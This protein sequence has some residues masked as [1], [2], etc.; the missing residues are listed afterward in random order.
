MGAYQQLCIILS[1]LSKSGTI[2]SLAS[3]GEI[4]ISPDCNIQISWN[5]R[6]SKAKTSFVTLK[7]VSFA[8]T[9]N[10]H[11]TRALFRC[12]IFSR[13]PCRIFCSSASMHVDHQLEC[14]ANT[15]KVATSNPAGRVF[16]F[17]FCAGVC[18]CGEGEGW[19]DLCGGVCVCCAPTATLAHFE[20]NFKMIIRL[21]SCTKSSN[22]IMRIDVTLMLTYYL[23]FRRVTSCEY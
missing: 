9:F 8:I 3:L 6:H 20:I 21:P 14:C 17:V 5:K 4:A 15:T 22:H 10:L 19:D 2:C 7:Y 16:C 12:T 18:V 1:H 13:T 23:S 11:Q